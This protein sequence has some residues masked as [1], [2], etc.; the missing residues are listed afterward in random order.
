MSTSN[1]SGPVFVVDFGAQYAQ[2]IARRV[3]ECH[4]YSEIVG[5][6]I[7]V[8]ELERRAPSAL[9]RLAKLEVEVR[10]E[11]IQVK[12]RRTWRMRASRR[13]SPPC[14]P[15]AEIVVLIALAS[16]LA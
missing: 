15:R 12:R 4:V 1:D 7:G 10:S 2:L 8:D 16:T 6:D 13:A 14:A 11:N 9:G 5:N 3:R